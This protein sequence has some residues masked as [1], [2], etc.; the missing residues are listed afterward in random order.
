MRLTYLPGGPAHR[1][2]VEEALRE[3]AADFI[4]ALNEKRIRSFADDASRPDRAILAF[5]KETLVGTFIFKPCEPH[6]LTKNSFTAVEQFRG[7]AYVR[8]LFVLPAFRNS[9][10]GRRIRE[11]GI[12]AIRAAGF[13]GVVAT[14]WKKN[15]TM[16]RINRAMGFL[17]VA[18]VPAPWR[19]PGEESLITKKEFHR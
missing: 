13:G 14:C 6:D 3:R 5:H 11:R 9:G 7:F 15:E 8:V 12:S 18:A 4:P 2:A 1:P 17:L 10:L 19:G 16:K